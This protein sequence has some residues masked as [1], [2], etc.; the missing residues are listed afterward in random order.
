MQ[1]RAPTMD[2]IRDA[3]QVHL[4]IFPVERIVEVF[5][6]QALVASP[7]SHD[8]MSAWKCGPHYSTNTGI[9]AGSVTATR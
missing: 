2:D 7:D 1:D 4:V 3:A 6:E 5:V 8:L 9:H